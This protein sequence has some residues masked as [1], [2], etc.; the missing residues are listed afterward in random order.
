MTIVDIG[1]PKRLVEF[2]VDGETVRVPEGSTILDACTEAGKEIPTLCYGDTLEPANAC[3]VCMVEVEGSRTLVPS[4]SRK[5]EPGMVVRTDSER[6][7][8][9]RKVVLELLASATDLSTTPGVAEWL[10]ETGADPDRFGP[11]AA[12]VAQPAIVDNELYVRDYGK[13]ILCYKCVDACG[14]QWQNSFAITVAGRG[15]DARIS[16][17]FSNPLPDSACVYCGNCVEVCPTGA[18]SF[19]RE[20]DKRED[21]TW[22]ETRQKQTTTV[23][24]FCGV[25]CNLTLHVQ[26]NEIV[27]VTSP[28]DSSVTHGNLCIKGR[29]GWQHVQNR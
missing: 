8:T 17:E 27:K 21:G 19:K 1:I 22:D 13:C 3:R 9:S 11:D 24:T 15:F 29:F 5:A 2:T 4:C 16:T 25:G 10:A 12:T 6:T 14:E 26:D 23:C 7:R 20:Y 18:L 28:H